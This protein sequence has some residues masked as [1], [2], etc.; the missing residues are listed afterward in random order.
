MATK[1]WVGQQ[2]YLTS[3]SI[4]DM[5]TK[6]WVGQQGYL[7]AADVSGKVDKSTLTTY[8]TTGSGGVLEQFPTTGYNLAQLV[9]HYNVLLGALEDIIG[10]IS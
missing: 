2:G 1:T 9:A 7:K 8:L 5:A 4:S 3:S 10:A 6:T